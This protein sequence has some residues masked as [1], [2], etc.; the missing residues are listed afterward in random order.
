M[1]TIS[2]KLNCHIFSETEEILVNSKKSRNQY[3]KEAILHYNQIQKDKIMYE[4]STRDTK[5]SLRLD[6]GIFSETEMILKYRKKPIIHYIKEAIDY[7][8]KIQKS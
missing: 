6:D 8:N 5:I 3:I 2:L 4:A 7:Y 1:K